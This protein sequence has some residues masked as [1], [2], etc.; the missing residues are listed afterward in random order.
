M[1]VVMASGKFDLHIYFN[2]LLEF[3][4]PHIR[5]DFII[6]RII[7]VAMSYN[8]YSDLDNVKMISQTHKY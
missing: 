6:F 2:F 7:Y 5:K 4:L 1:F 3:Y 8:Q